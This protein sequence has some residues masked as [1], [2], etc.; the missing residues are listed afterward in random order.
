[1]WLYM[2][3]GI[4]AGLVAAV[5]AYSYT[6]SFLLDRRIARK[7]SAW[8]SS[9]QRSPPS[10]ASSPWVGKRILVVVNPVGGARRSRGWL[11]NLVLPVLQAHRCVVTTLE[12]TR[13]GH[14]AEFITQAD[15]ERFDLLML[16]SGDGLLNEALNALVSRAAKSD[17]QLMQDPASPAYHAALS[18]ALHA[19]PIAL[20]PGGTSNGLVASLFGPLSDVVDVLRKVL[21][22]PPRSVDIMSVQSPASADD[23]VATEYARRMAAQAQAAGTKPIVHV[24]MLCALYGV[25]GDNDDYAERKFRSWPHLLRTT[26]APLMAILMCPSSGYGATVRFKPMVA[27]SGSNSKDAAE[28]AA[29][30]HLS[31]TSS[32]SSW[33]EDPSWKVVAARWMS[34][35]VLNQPFPASDVLMAPSALPDDGCL[36]LSAVRAPLSKWKLLYLFTLMG[37]GG[38]NA[39]AEC[40]YY[41]VSEVVIHPHSDSSHMVISGELL[42]VRSTSIRVQHKAAFFV[43]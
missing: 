3:A 25:I 39:R 43:Y 38:H 27:A 28:E 1:M 11:H 22:S 32:L 9:L 2:L 7:T 34:L 33:A 4:L 30:W 13:A 6:S 29:R 5:T 21:S 37:D 23:S 42:P 15:L 14:A 24:D 36:Y 40:D 16:I 41:R 26:L 31:P 20:L 8:L 10:A 35:V 18:R 17:P 12:T 19:L